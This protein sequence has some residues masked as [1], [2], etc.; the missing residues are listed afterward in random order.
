VLV[1]TARPFQESADLG[2]LLYAFRRSG[3]SL[4][5]LCLTRGE[6]VTQRGATRVAHACRPAVSSP[7]E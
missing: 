7:H 2:G 1:V 3:A 5:L 6:T 4:S